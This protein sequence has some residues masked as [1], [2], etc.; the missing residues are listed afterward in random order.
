[1]LYKAVAVRIKRY[2]EHKRT[3]SILQNYGMLHCTNIPEIS[4][5]NQILLN[6]QELVF[7]N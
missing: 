4:N 2:Y 3:H 1:M 5:K 7:L 6:V